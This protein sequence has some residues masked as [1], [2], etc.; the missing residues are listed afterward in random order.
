[1]LLWEIDYDREL[2]VRE[3]TLEIIAVP[4]SARNF[5]NGSRPGLVRKEGHRSAL[6]ASAEICGLGFAACFA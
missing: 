4:S 5:G 2:L 3:D 6:G 1:L